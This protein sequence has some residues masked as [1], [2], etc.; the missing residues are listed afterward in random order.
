MKLKH[1]SLSFEELQKTRDLESELLSASAMLKSFLSTVEAI[2]ACGHELAKEDT[3]NALSAACT[4][5]I[6]ELRHLSVLENKGRGYLQ[7][8][9]LIQQRTSIVIGLVSIKND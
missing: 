1:P 5:L 6:P 7:S 2:Q 9:E 3:T 4:V 8:V